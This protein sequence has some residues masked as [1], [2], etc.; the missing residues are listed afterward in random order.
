MNGSS[1]LSMSCV[2]GCPAPRS[3]RGAAASWG[4]L[5]GHVE[6][7]QD[8]R[9][10]SKNRGHVLAGVILAALTAGERVQ[11][12]QADHHAIRLVTPNTRQA[13]EWLHCVLKAGFQV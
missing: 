8:A 4:G 5:L 2:L 3:L 7:R 13:R 1:M 9:I 11:V 6:P 10:R 12:V